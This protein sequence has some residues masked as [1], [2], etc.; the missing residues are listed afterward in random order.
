MARI[1]IRD[2]PTSQR[3]DRRALRA[4]FGGA[5]WGLPMAIGGSVPGL[6]IAY[7]G[8]GKTAAADAGLG[9]L[10]KGEKVSY[11]REDVG[12]GGC[13]PSRYCGL[14]STVPR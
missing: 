3:T 14:S 2:L 7:H 6:A 10:Q 4:V 8:K 11:E 5:H 12:P 9:K 1:E 13:L